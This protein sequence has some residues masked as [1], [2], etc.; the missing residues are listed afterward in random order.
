MSATIRWVA[1]LCGFLLCCPLLSQADSKTPDRRQLTVGLMPYLTT[2][3]LLANYQPIAEALEKSLKQ[4]VMLQ[5]AP[6]FDTFVKRILDGEYDVALLAPHYARLATRDYGYTS[7]LL[8]KAPIRGVLASSRSKPLTS[9]DDLRGEDISVVDRSALIVIAGAITLA[10]N[11][12]KENVDYRFVETISHSS[13]LHNA[14]SGKARAALV[15]YSTLVLAAPDLQR[16]TQVW[17][18][19]A[20]I[21]GQFYIAH[22]RIPA[23]RQQAVKAALLAFEKSPEGQHFFDKTKHGGFREPTAE[24]YVLLDRMLP[25]TRRQLGNTLR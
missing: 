13:A 15:S 24:D 19:V 6:D 7:L 1:V 12:L 14:I 22:N 23:A 20:T 8:H 16:D 17:R 18:D 5:T 4:P 9:F 2:R 25:E 10:E 3:T 11:G 21:P